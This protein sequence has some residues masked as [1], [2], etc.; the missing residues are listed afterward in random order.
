[1]DNREKNYIRILK[2]TGET[3]EIS[4]SREQNVKE[5]YKKKEN[6]SRTYHRTGSEN[7]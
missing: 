6:C 5:E 4:K 7:S 2:M 1:M 3:I